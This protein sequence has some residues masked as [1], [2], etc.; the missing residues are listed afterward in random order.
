MG[1]KSDMSS[2]QREVSMV[3]GMRFARKH[4]LDFLEVSW[5]GSSVVP[6]GC[7]LVM[8]AVFFFLLVA[9]PSGVLQKNR[10]LAGG[11]RS[12]TRN[13]SCPWRSEAEW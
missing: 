1:N 3:E 8:G 13:R 7:R 5:L 12:S 10:C 4:G 11:G 2:K 9:D 6:S